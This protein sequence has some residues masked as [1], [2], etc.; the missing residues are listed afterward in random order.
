MKAS[1][2]NRFIGCST[3]EAEHPA[4]W[5]MSLARM[6]PRQGHTKRRQSERATG[7]LNRFVSS[8]AIHV[9]AMS[10]GLPD[11]RVRLDLSFTS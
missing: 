3:T 1:A 11:L 9:P 8:K 5:R 10:L 7:M 4:A 2:L 6:A